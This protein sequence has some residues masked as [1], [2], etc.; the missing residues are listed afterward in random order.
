MTGHSDHDDAERKWAELVAALSK[1]AQGTGDW[2]DLARSLGHMLGKPW[3]SWQDLSRAKEEVRTGLA[4]SDAAT[5]GA[6]RISVAA[7]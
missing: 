1:G 2:G 6:T 4:E 7:R 3:L 5:P